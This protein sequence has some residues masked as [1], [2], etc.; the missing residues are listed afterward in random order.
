M[1][2][3]ACDEIRAL[4]PAQLDG[5]L[6]P[7]AAARVREHLEACPACREHREDLR[8]AVDALRRLPDLPAPASILAGVRARL[9][10]VPWHRRLLGRRPW[11]VGVPAGALATAL[12]AVG[13]ALFQARYPRLPQAV[14]ERAVP[15]PEIARDVRRPVPEPEPRPQAPVGEVRSGVPEPSPAPVAKRAPAPPAQ[16]AVKAAPPPAVRTRAAGP[17]HPQA[18]QIAGEP[19]PGGEVPLSSAGAGDIAG[20][21]HGARICARAFAPAR[22][23]AASRPTHSG[24]APHGTD[25]AGGA[26]SA[27]CAPAG[28]AAACALR[29]SRAGPRAGTGRIRAAP[30]LHAA[31]AER[32]PAPGSVAP[33]PGRDARACR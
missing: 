31:G 19:P 18:P 12:V 3:R 2:G 26:S 25:P 14:G 33:G 13:V 7:G 20:A 15:P 32:R 22:A 1:S 11:L 29:R 5:D 30:H 9:R 6:E 16:T 23:R 21:R 28:D 4:L 17:R 8:L 24:R 10:P 27:G